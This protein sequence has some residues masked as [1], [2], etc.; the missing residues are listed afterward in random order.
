VNRTGAEPHPRGVFTPSR[1]NASSKRA[2]HDVS[3]LPVVDGRELVGILD[4][5]DVMRYIQVKKHLSEMG[6]AP[7]TDRT[8]AH[9]TRRPP[10][11]GTHE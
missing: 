8:G 4:R 10:C 3:Q 11:D 7:G 9:E 2:E 6:A 1:W 5:G